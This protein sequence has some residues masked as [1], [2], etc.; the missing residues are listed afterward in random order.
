MKVLPPR[1]LYLLATRSSSIGRAVGG[2]IKGPSSAGTS[3]RPLPRPA[4]PPLAAAARVAIFQILYKQEKSQPTETIILLY[5]KV[6]E[7][8]ER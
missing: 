3:P 7:L 1:F 5:G 8:K 4:R 2:W 6:E